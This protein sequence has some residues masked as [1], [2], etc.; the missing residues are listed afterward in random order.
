MKINYK[1]RNSELMIS[2]VASKTVKLIK[3]I[4]EGTGDQKF[5]LSEVL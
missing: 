3:S 4:F 5:G 2:H 1:Q